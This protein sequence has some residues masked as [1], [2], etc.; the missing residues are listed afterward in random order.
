[1]SDERELALQREI[2]TDVAESVM[3][4]AGVQLHYLVGTMIELPR[5]ALLAGEI[6]KYADFFS[7]GTN[8][9]TQTT[10]GISRDDAATFMPLYIERGIFKD[11][12][13]QVLDRDGVG[14]LIQMATWEGRQRRRGLKGGSCGETGGA[15]P[16][17]DF[18]HATGL[19]YG[20]CSPCRV[21]VARLAAADAALRSPAPARKQAELRALQAESQAAEATIG[22]GRV[23]AP[24]RA[25]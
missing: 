19:A 7:F 10:Y 11:D 15:T 9:L 3:Q 1:I 14:Q 6:A 17:I 16:S 18:C 5:A 12:P 22:H 24:P 2:V 13:F 25:G 23:A 21:P 4:Q 8:D 20:S